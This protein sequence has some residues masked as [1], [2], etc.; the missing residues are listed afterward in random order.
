MMTLLGRDP[1]PEEICC[2][3]EQPSPKKR[4]YSAPL[5][6]SSSELDRSRRRSD[7]QELDI[8]DSI[9]FGM[10]MSSKV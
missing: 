2:S 5:C 9:I 1:M 6:Q 10:W 3:E 7:I 4:W 8:A